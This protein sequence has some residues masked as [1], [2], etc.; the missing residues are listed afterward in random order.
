MNDAFENQAEM[1]IG[2]CRTLIARAS[3]CQID[4]LSPSF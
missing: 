2:D 4:S 3:K 1:I